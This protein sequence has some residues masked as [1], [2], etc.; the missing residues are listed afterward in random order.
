MRA[1]KTSEYAAKRRLELDRMSATEA[2]LGWL[3]CG[4]RTPEDIC[5]RSGSLRLKTV[6]QTLAYLVES[7]TVAQADNVYAL[8]ND[9]EHWR[10]VR[11]MV[12][13]P[14]LRSSEY[15]GAWR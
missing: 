9:P 2:V 13:Q 6:H 14:Q 4:P 10:A 5:A 11:W 7:G 12:G 3:R 8:V 15:Y 1:G